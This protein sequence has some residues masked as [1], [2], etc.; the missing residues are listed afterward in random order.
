M[1]HIEHGIGVFDGLVRMELAGIEREYLQVSYARGDRLYVPVHQADRL[2]RYVG[3]G[4]NTPAVS[5]LGTADWGLVKERAKRAVAEIADDLLKLY[6][7]REMVKGYV[8]SPDTPWQDEMEALFPYQET[9]DQLHAVAA[10][11]RDMESDRPMDRL[12]CGDVGY[13][14][15]E[16]AIRAAFKAINDGK[17]VAFLV[18][19]TV[20][21]QQH[22]RNISNR[23]LRFPVRVDVLSRFRTQSQQQKTIDGLRTG[24][25]DLV[26]GTH[27]LLSEDV[28]FKDLGLLIIDEEQRFGVAQKE[29]LKQLRTKVD[30][31]TL[32]AT[33]IPR[34]LHMSLSG[35]RDMSTINTP[36]KE[37][38]PV[39]TVLSE[40][41][42]LLLKQAIQREI[43]RKG[44][45][46]VV[47]DRVRG[48][49]ALADRIERLVPDAVVA[50]GHG[51]MHERALED[52]MV[53][54]AEG[55]VDV[56][57]ATTIIENGLDIPNANTIIIN[58]ADKF[59]LARLYQLRG[60]VGRSAL[61]G[62]CYLL[63]DK[64][65]ALSYD[66][67]RR[68]EAI[69]ESSE[70]LGAGFRI[71]MRDLEI[72]G[73]GEL[74]GARQH[75]N[76]DSV[77]FDLYTRLLAQAIN[78][79][80]RKKERFEK[81]IGSDGSLVQGTVEE[82]TQLTVVN[83]AG[84]AAGS[85]AEGERHAVV[86][87]AEEEQ[88]PFDLEDPLAPPVVLDLPIDAKIPGWYIED[89]G[90]RL[91]LYRRIAG[92][93]HPEVLDEMR[94]ELVD[95]FGK[96][97]ETGSVPEEVENLFFQ[98]RVKIVATRAGVE[99]IGRDMDNLVLHSDALENMDRKTMQRRLRL[100]LG[101][102]SEEDGTFHADDAARVGRR[103]IYLPI[104][105]AGL[106][107]QVLLRTL[108]IMAVG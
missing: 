50:V 72:R 53:R 104:D 70:E 81:A 17:Q 100:G 67:S 106:W 6:A 48:I 93:T 65:A 63:Y 57:V 43:N 22:Y 5:R 101:K 41:D 56:L 38:Q 21:A 76:I 42:D 20:L 87:L 18:P 46:F 35:I 62:H 26:V 51:Q 40:Y 37:R 39:H 3:A 24:K 69:L 64:N 86:T 8:Y 92:I 99:R 98:I 80:R 88:I 47:N 25:V 10:V 23:L 78:E 77:G 28:E 66:A 71:A 7:E 11:K 29:Q 68:L 27:R 107:R 13:G 1:V 15:T 4:D 12:I 52:V 91:Q 105:E 60:R 30:V 83:E 59:G 14:K 95:R 73:A 85:A 44:Q 74:L 58:R 75:G 36:P 79:A 102:I 49:Q 103:S 19:T 84:V 9:D 89:E 108:E 33:P 54:F 16:V 55:D 61:R 96:D 90:L 2:S 34:T 32:S 82:E 97:A 45:V 31:L 94:Q